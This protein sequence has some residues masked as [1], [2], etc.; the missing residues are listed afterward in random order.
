MLLDPLH[1]AVV[2]FPVVLAFLLPLFAAGALWAIR[3]GAAPRRA[4]LLPI[5]GAAALALSAW[6][7]VE[8]GEAQTERVERVVSEQVIEGHEEMAEAFLA[9]TAA[10]AVIALA[11]LAGG[12]PGKAARIVT[13]AGA[14]AL[15]GL[16]A[17]VGHSGGQLVYRH[18]A[19][20][21]YTSPLSGGNAQGKRAAVLRRAHDGD[22]PSQ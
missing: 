9:A 7:A 12:L 6:V 4:W 14:L 19:A 2:H 15:V 21:A 16:A 10:V 17:R 5:A 22:V 13:A 1:P 20:S 8:T 11:G 18:G 3:R